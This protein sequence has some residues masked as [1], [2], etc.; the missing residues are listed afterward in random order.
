MAGPELLELVKLFANMPT[1]E[2]FA[3]IVKSKAAGASTIVHG[4]GIESGPEAVS[5]SVV[6][7]PDVI[8]PDVSEMVSIKDRDKKRLCEGH[9]IKGHHS[10]KLKEPLS[11]PSSTSL[12]LLSEAGIMSSPRLE[13][14]MGVSGVSTKSSLR[15][16]KG[17]ADKVPFPYISLLFSFIH[18]YPIALLICLSFLFLFVVYGVR[19]DVKVG[20]CG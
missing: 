10:K 5:K 12:G 6:P 13:T 3:R 14:I 2:F 18:I 4:V 7:L 9:S 20:R 17:F 8:G 11:C 19:E 1:E 16:C 15:V